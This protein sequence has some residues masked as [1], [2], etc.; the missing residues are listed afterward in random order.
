MKQSRIRAIDS[1]RGVA[2]LFVFLAHFNEY[3]LGSNGKSNQLYF[4]EKFT[5]LASPTFIIIS[6]ITLG[7]LFSINKLNFGQT[8]RKLVDRGLFLITIAHVLI[9]LSWI[10][11]EIF[12]HGQILRVLFTPGGI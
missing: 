5:K 6:G 2:M 3:Y 7:F 12:F 8:K 4:L 1:G 10:P 9:A 11:M